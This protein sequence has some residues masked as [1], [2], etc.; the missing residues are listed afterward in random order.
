[1]QYPLGR[2][3]QQA[4]L[5][6]LVGL[7]PLGLDDRQ[8]AADQRETDDDL[9]CQDE[10]AGQRAGVKQ[11]L[12]ESNGFVDVEGRH[13]AAELPHQ[14]REDVVAGCAIEVQA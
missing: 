1:V 7:G 14:Q 5:G 4:Y 2:A 3:G 12:L 6:R 11:R 8:N 9:E 10:P 13:H